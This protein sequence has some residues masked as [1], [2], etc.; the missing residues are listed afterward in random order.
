MRFKL[1]L[2][3]AALT[4][5]LTAAGSALAGSFQVSPVRIELSPSAPTA[6][7]N[8]R[9]ESTTD[10]VVVQLRAVN[11][12]QENGE[13]AYTPSTDL[14]ATPPIFTLQPGGSQTVRVG[15]R[16]AE[17]SDTQQTFRLFITEV[18]GP[19]KPGFQGLQVALNIG[20]PVFIAPKVKQTL[21]PVW[22]AQVADGKVTLVATNPAN[23]HIQLLDIAVQDEQDKVA[24]AS[25]QQPRYILARQTIT[26]QL[27]LS[28]A[29]KGKLRV[30][31][32]TDSGD[33]D[34][35]VPVEAA[36]GKQ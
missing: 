12:K 34:A 29:P 11:W 15:L 4:G 9:N 7:V 36:P 2:P 13:D 18:P 35:E 32:H 26:W 27:P 22:K 24:I 8:V 33:V 30:V 16:R 6:P 3:L 5:L 21:A 14:I 19:P 28:R 10:S 25:S 23:S 1:L 31:A 17:P 20:I